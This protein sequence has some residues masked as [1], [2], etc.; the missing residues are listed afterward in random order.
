MNIH[1]FTYII[2]FIVLFFG[3]PCTYEFNSECQDISACNYSET[4]GNCPTY[5]HDEE[6]CEYAQENFDCDGNCI[7]TTSIDNFQ[8]NVIA[9][10]QPW[11]IMSFDPVI[12]E[13]NYFGVSNYASDGYD[14]YDIPEPPVGGCTNC[15]NAYFSHAEWDSSFGDNFTQEFQSN[16]F[17]NTK[18]WN[19][20]VKATCGGSSSLTFNYDSIPSNILIEILYD[21]SSLVISDG[22]MIE[23]TLSPNIAKDFLIKVSVN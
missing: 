11:D 16:L 2:P 18:E 6:L 8:I 5:I 15:I 3:C 22:S 12:D 7:D 20:D 19:L 17:C 1:N 9:T 13:Q 10:I 4:K 21:D 14:S 23:F